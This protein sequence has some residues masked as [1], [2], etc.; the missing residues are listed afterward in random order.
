[1][2]FWGVEVKPGKG[3][4]LEPETYVHI[5]QAALG[6]NPTDGERVVL[7]VANEGGDPIVL[8]TL[9]KGKCDQIHL[10][11]VFDRDF[12]LFHTGTSSVY[13][14]GYTTPGTLY[15][16]L[17]CCIEAAV[18]ENGRAAGKLIKSTQKAAKAA[19]ASRAAGEAGSKRAAAGPMPV[20]AKKLKA[21]TPGKKQVTPATKGAPATA[22]ATP[23]PGKTLTPAAKSSQKPAKSASPGTPGTP[24]SGKKPGLGEYTCTPCNSTHLQNVQADVAVL[25]DVGVEAV[26]VELH[27]WCL[28]GI[29]TRKPEAQLVGEPLIDGAGAPLDGACPLEDVVPFW[30]RGDAGV[31]TS[32]SSSTDKDSAVYGQLEL[33]S[34]PA[35]PISRLANWPSC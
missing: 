22:K 20:S 14:V 2:E 11:L 19:I 33:P 25:V 28:E 16:L 7:Q 31:S 13:F 18:K 1:M 30:E 29:L 27:R 21:E 9:S 10:D 23:S 8:G 6:A 4:E 34:R 3:L 5:S 15:P 12:R 26:G 17:Y 32:L 35:V 24:G